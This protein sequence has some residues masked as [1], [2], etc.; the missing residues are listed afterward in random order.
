MPILPEARTIARAMPHHDTLPE[1]SSDA[2]AHSARL[3]QH[4]REHIDEAGG[5]I[6]FSQYMKLALYAPELG[7]Y[8]A[9]S[10]KLGKDGDFTTAPE[11]TPLFGQALAQQARQ[12]IDDGLTDILEIGAGSGVLAAAMLEELERL[13]ALPERYLI[14]ELSPELRARE[15]DTLAARVPH[16]MERVAWLN[17]LPPAFSG[18]V[19]GNEVLDAMPVEIVRTADMGIE[20]GG[21]DTNLIWSFR[22]ATAQVLEAATALRLPP[23]YRTEIGL[24]SQAFVRTLAE[25]LE[26]GAILLIDYGFPRAEYYH[27]QRAAGT[28]MCHYRHRAHDDPFYLPGLQDITAHVDFTAMAEAAHA[29]GLEVAGYTT[30]AHL[31][32]NLGITDLLMRIPPDDAQRYLPAAAAVNKL[33]SPAEMGELFK[34]VAFT[35]DIDR[36]LL[37]FRSGDRRHT[38]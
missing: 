4:I 3:V 28:L 36:P 14:L 20:Q 5:W 37:G 34:A 23:D 12:L 33:M 24:A 27:P 15:R 13:D 18:L 2:S 21:V 1:P 6:P 25:I 10:R 8:T 29:G 17:Q 31:L 35:R 16:L 26:R 22:P 9:G 32:I 11:L 7:Y 38:L 30:Q 19:L